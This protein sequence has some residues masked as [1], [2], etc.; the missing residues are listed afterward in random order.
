MMRAGGRSRLAHFV[1]VSHPYKERRPDMKKI[2]AFVLVGVATAAVGT[3]FLMKWPSGTSP[4]GNSPTADASASEKPLSHW[5]EGVKSSN[6]AIR[7]QAAL[8]L[9][10]FGPAAKSA[11]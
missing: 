5:L 6:P 8:A 10:G 1:N 7:K 2:I 9:S 11:T 4:S 3:F